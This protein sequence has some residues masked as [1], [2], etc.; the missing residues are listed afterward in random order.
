MFN[1]IKGQIKSYLQRGHIS[2]E[3]VLSWPLFIDSIVCKSL[4]WAG[5]L[6]HFVILAETLL[7]VV[8]LRGL[9]AFILQL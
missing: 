1:L 4:V 5:I 6:L 9:T 8:S 3:K 2:F 7:S